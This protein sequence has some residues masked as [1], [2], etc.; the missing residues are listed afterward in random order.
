[1]KR[2]DLPKNQLE[3]AAA[4]IIGGERWVDV[5]LDFGVGRSALRRNLKSAGIPVEIGKGRKTQGA[6]LVAPNSGG[7]WDVERA[8]R[9]LREPLMVS[10]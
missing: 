1:M 4:R 6:G 5:A 2:K 10:A 7:G 9:M 8:S 3:Q